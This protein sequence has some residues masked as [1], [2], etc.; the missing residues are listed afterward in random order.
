[1]VDGR[2]LTLKLNPIWLGARPLVQ[3]DLEIERQE[4]DKLEI[5][6]SLETGLEPDL[7][8][9]SDQCH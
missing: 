2:R 3:H 1:M 4:L 9:I 8:T 5:V 6:L 7:E